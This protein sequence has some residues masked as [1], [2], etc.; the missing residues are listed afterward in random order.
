MGFVCTHPDCKSGMD[1][2][3]H[4][5]IPLKN[6]GLDKFN[7]F[8]CLCKECHT[9]NSLHSRW[10]NLEL[11]LTTWKFYAELNILGTTSDCP[12]K[13]FLKAVAKIKASKQGE[14]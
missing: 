8:I 10:K 5:I 9:T 13:E 14:D 11:E 1:I 4:H 3:T 7:N 2:E 6:G 12:D